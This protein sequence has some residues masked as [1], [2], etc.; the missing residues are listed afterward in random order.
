MFL[1]PFR[2]EWI[3]G[4][5]RECGTL[6]QKDIPPHVSLCRG[7]LTCLELQPPHKHTRGCDMQAHNAYALKC[8]T[9]DS[10]SGL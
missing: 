3:Q 4:P 8:Q 7:L 10:E 1:S 9:F 6:D 2:T 5:A